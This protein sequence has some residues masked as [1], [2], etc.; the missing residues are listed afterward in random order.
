LRLSPIALA[1]VHLSGRG[2]NG[3]PLPFEAVAAVL[4]KANVRAAAAG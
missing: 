3:R 4:A 1:A 2:L